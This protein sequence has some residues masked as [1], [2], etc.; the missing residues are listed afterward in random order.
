[1]V[2]L[3][4]PDDLLGRGVASGCSGGGAGEVTRYRIA[5]EATTKEAVLWV[6]RYRAAGKLVVAH[7]ALFHLCTAAWA[8]G[9]IGGNVTILLRWVDN[10]LS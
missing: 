7:S 3:A 8:A 10:A 1:M 6:E 9:C 5:A 2:A 4:V